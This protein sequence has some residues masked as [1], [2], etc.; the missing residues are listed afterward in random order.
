MSSGAAMKFRLLRL[1][2]LL[3]QFHALYLVLR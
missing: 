1:E 2:L 3:I